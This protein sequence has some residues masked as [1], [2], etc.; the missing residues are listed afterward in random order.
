MATTL[1]EWMTPQ[2]AGEALQGFVA[3]RVTA[4]QLLRTALTEHGGTAATLLDGTLDAVAPVWDRIACRC[5]ELGV[6]RETLEKDPTR[7]S[8]PS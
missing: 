6:A 8:W 4:L 7:D 1:S 3:E 5:A 2:R